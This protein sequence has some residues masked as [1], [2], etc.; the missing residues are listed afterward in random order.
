MLYLKKMPYNS[1]CVGADSTTELSTAFLRFQE[2][3]ESPSDQFRGQV[4]TLGQYKLWYEKQYG[5]FSYYT[6]WSGFNIHSYVLEPF[7]RGLFDPLLPEEQNL[8]SLF[9]NAPKDRFYI[10]GANT[11]DVLDHE[12]NHAL[13]AYNNDY[14]DEVNKV[15]DANLENIKYA[16]EHLLDK[17]YCKYLLYDELQAYILDDDEYITSLIKDKKILEKILFLYL[18]YS[19]KHYET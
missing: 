11:K 12:L 19:E 3:Y 16:L 17:G 4:F 6:D 14:S 9:V 5:W 1:Y 10:I 8:V 15:F 18:Q 13:Y 7:K 2:H